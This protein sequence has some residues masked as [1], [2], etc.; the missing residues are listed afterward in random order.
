MKKP[1]SGTMQK[2]DNT[3]KKAESNT[4]ADNVKRLEL[5]L[6]LLFALRYHCL[7][8]LFY[9]KKFNMPTDHVKSQGNFGIPQVAAGCNL[10]FYLVKKSV[11][12]NGIDL[13]YDSRVTH[14]LFWPTKK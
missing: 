2:A 3:M 4:V 1:D 7:A 13:K 14:Y 12:F 11:S 6:R 5:S 8:I 10:I 9:S